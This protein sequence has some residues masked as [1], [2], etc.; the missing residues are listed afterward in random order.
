MLCVYFKVAEVD[1]PY[2]AKEGQITTKSNLTDLC[3]FLLRPSLIH[4]GADLTAT[5]EQLNLI[6]MDSHYSKVCFNKILMGRRGVS[7]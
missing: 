1:R 6:L 5:P 3:R 4:C 2:R 7:D